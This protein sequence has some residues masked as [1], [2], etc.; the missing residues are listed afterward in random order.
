MCQAAK[1][2]YLAY[3]WKLMQRTL[4]S[5]KIIQQNDQEKCK[6]NFVAKEEEEE[7]SEFDE[8]ESDKSESEPLYF[9]ED[10]SENE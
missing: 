1:L 10:N 3:N 5:H 9:S 7:I 8:S 2:T 6:E 4:K